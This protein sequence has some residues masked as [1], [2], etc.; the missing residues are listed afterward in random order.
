MN[1]EIYEPYHS[2]QSFF[3]PGLGL[4]L[5]IPSQCCCSTIELLCITDHCLRVIEGTRVLPTFIRLAQLVPIHLNISS[6]K[7]N[8]RN[9][10]IREFGSGSK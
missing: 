5:P 10:T 8:L 4:L 6:Q 1:K 7:M 9:I 3:D 2:Y